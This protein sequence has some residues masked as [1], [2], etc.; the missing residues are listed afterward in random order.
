MKTS[1]SWERYGYLWISIT[2][3]VIGEHH[4]GMTRKDL[5]HGILFLNFQKY[6]KKILKIAR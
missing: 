4:L 6:K 5:Q 2:I 1:Q 3:Q